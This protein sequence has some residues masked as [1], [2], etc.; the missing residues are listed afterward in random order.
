MSEPTAAPPMTP[1]HYQAIAALAL[2]ALIPFLAPLVAVLR[3]IQ[4]D[5]E[6]KHLKRHLID[7]KE[8]EQAVHRRFKEEQATLKAAMQA[9]KGGGEVTR[10]NLP[11][12]L[13]GQRPAGGSATSPVGDRAA[14]SP[15]P[16]SASRHF[17]DQ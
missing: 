15:L 16:A 8:Q 9:V 10:M 5:E 11:D 3:Y 1:R 12:R 4:V 17:L 13:P 14:P 7:L 6:R 2:I